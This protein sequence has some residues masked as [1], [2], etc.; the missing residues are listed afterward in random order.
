[1]EYKNKYLKYKNKYLNLRNRINQFGGSSITELTIGQNII[2]NH[3][4]GWNSYKYL[5]T[6]VR[7]TEQHHFEKNDEYDGEGD[8]PSNYYINSFELLAS[9]VS[10]IRKEDNSIF[11]E[12]LPDI[13]DIRTQEHYKY[14][15][16]KFPDAVLVLI[17]DIKPSRDMDSLEEAR[18]NSLTAIIDDPN[19]LLPPIKIDT[20]NNIVDGH[21]RYNLSKILGFKYI[22]VIV[23]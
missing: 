22:P 14:N 4:G 7:D 19:I 12:F 1:M 16:Y 18:S 5:G 21:H 3:W 9:T 13:K 10:D 11:D 17:E 20:S 6:V 2:I 15:R 8:G 23:N